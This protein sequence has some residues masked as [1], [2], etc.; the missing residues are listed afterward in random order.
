MTST[1][2]WHRLEPRVRGADPAT[3]LRA[4]VH[5]P[6][7]LL[8]RQWQVGELLGEDAASPVAVRVETAEHRLSRWRPASG[9]AE[10]YDPSATPLEVL[11]EREP[12]VTPTLRDRLDAWT[13]LVELLEDAGLGDRAAALAGD[14][15]LPPPRVPEDPAEARLRLLAGDAAGDGLA[16]AESLAAEP[17]GLPA[18][19]VTTFLAWV[20]A[21]TSARAGDCWVTDRLEYRF[22]VGAGTDTG[23]VVLAAPEYLGGRLDWY[24]LD[25]DAD[26]A[27]ALGAAE[28]PVRSAVTH[29]LPTRVTFPGMPAERFWEFED[30][31]VDLGA[32]SAAAE[33]LGRLVTVEFATVFGNDWWSAPVRAP[34]G[35]L[36]GVRSLI[37]RDTFGEN[38]LV[39]PTEDAAEASASWRMF[40]LTDSEIGAGTGPAPPLL[41]LAP[42]VSGALDGD[43][44]E[45]LLLLR[46]EMANLAWGVERVVEGADARPRNRS[47]EY[48]SRL[49]AAAPPSLASPAELVYVLQTSVPDHWIPLVPV[50]DPEGSRAIVLQR[51]S[52]L[53]QD[54]TARPITAHGVLLSPEV[55]P[56]YFHEEEIPRTGLRVRR[57]PSVARWLD[58]T[59]YEWTSRRVGTG[60]GEGSSGLQ[61]DIGVPPAP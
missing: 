10:D 13:R 2:T 1:T 53:T 8:G 24:D 48:A 40:R 19:L 54:G 9:D 55:S 38:V 11:V 59:T 7:W 56:W 30:A 42:V 21:R 17:A 41:M 45:E 35:S 29:L 34:F 44:V 27:H 61:F 49:T 16:V 36:V 58:G 39:E 14:N 37:V 4:A 23:E 46:D 12:P 25:V 18:G 51:G 3:G 47:V 26:P 43:A 31:A 57:I 20:R 33:D 50:R 60:A 52:L 28:D 32:V 22:S 6:L 5:D 15:P